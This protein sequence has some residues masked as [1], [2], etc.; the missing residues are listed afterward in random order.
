MT[1][2]AHVSLKLIGVWGSILMKLTLIII[3]VKSLQA[4]PHRGLFVLF[5]VFRVVSPSKLVYFH[6]L[7]EATTVSLSSTSTELSHN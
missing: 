3:W 1:L 6:I 4:I 2:T 7:G 5:K